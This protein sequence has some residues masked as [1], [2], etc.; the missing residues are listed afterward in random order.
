MGLVP[1]DEVRYCSP[2]AQAFV[3]IFEQRREQILDHPPRAGLDLDRHRHAGREVDHAV[4]DLHLRLVER[5]ARGIDQLLVRAARSSCA[6]PRGWPALLLSVG[7]SRVIASGDTLITLPCDQAVAGEIEG[8][9][10]DLARPARH[11]RSRCRGCDTM[12]SISSWLSLGTTT[13]SACAGV[14]TPPIVCTASCCTVPSTG[15]VRICSWVRCVRL[16]RD[17]R[18]S[19]SA[20]RSRFDQIGISRS[21]R[22]SASACS[23]LFGDRGDRGRGL[24]SV[25]LLHRELLLLFDQV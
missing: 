20:L 17:P 4:L 8:V 21:R 22:N 5:D 24:C 25:A 2:V 11:A 3:A 15:A 6:L 13:S 7:L 1:E 12:A 9:D 10:L 16:D 18:S 23:A 14:T 19:P